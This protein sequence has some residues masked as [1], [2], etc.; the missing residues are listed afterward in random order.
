MALRIAAREAFRERQERTLDCARELAADVV[1][2]GDGV[3][4]L[5]G[6]TDV[7]LVLVDL[8]TSE[9]SGQDAE[10]RL[11]GGHHRQPQ[12]DSVDPRPPKVTSGLRIG[13][14]AMVTRGLGRED[15]RRDR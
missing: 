5:T 8:R 4:V 11:L 7:H 2:A 6:G 14:P 12:R 3:E 1:G 13:S 15:F 9:L 10:D